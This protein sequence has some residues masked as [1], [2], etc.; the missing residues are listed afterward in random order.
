MTSQPVLT[1]SQRKDAERK[2]DARMAARL[3]ESVTGDPSEYFTTHEVSPA[4]REA[5]L[6]RGRS[7]QT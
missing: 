7:S 2:H 6:A 4:R 5:S 1:E 3:D